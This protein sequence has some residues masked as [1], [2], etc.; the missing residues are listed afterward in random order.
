MLELKNLALGRS[1]VNRA[2]FHST[3]QLP[4][5]PARALFVR[6]GEV[7][8]AGAKIDFKNP[9]LFPE[10]DFAYLGSDANHNYL[11]NLSSVELAGDWTALRNIGAKLDDL[12]AGLATSGLALFNWHQNNPICNRCGGETQSQQHGW[13]RVCLV[14]KSQHFPR[15]DPAVILLVTN[16]QNEMLLA[17][18][19]VWP[20]RQYSVIAGFVEAGETLEAT[21]AREAYEEV[22]IEIANIEYLGSQPW[23]FP[24]SLMLA[25]QASS[26]NTKLTPD[27]SE[28]VE[29]FW[30]SKDELD[31][32]CQTGEIKLPPHTSIARQMIDHWYGT[33]T[34]DAW[35]R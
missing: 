23:P 11:V 15:T 26:Q 35:T 13:S 2:H 19:G 32:K 20:E 29:A 8:L 17:R 27:G 9:A 34:P 25:F 10:T 22:G 16:P 1:A 14:D 28:I 4:N 31:A 33:K 21:C 30:I 3:S 18:Q 5:L 7:L 12:E 24:Q 6:T